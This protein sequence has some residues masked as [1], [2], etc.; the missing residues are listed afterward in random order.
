MKPYPAALRAGYSKS[1]AKSGIYETL[2][3][4]KDLYKKV[5]GISKNFREVYPEFCTNMLPDIAY[6]ERR[7]VEQLVEKPEDMDAVKAKVVRD[8]KRSAGVLGDDHVRPVQVQVNLAV[9][10][11]HQEEHLDAITVESEE[12]KKE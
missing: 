10:Q 4:K 11:G 9:L 12:S 2:G 1:Y 6:I 7:I 8:M 5:Q 3:L